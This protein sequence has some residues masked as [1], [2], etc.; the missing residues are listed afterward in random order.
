MA[1]DGW[2]LR[3]ISEEPKGLM[4]IVASSIAFH[5]SS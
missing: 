2:D 3:Y 5:E 1:E 4:G